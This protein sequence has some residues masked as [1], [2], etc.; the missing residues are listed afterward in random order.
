MRAWAWSL[1][2]NAACR[3]PG[4]T[5]SSANA[6][7]PVSR[8]GEEQ[9][10][11]RAVA[12]DQHRAGAAHAVLAADMGARESERV[13]QEIAEQQARL[14]RALVG[15]AVHRHGEGLGA[16]HAAASSALRQA[17]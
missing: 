3:A 16:A 1:R 7:W 2:R 11:A 8:D 4:I 12:V 9:A 14:D 6:P 15:R 13:A 17:R 5:R 10:G